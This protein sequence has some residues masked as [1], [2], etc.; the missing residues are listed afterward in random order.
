MTNQYYNPTIVATPGTTVRSAQFNDNNNSLNEGFDKL[1][2]PAVLFTNRQNFAVATSPTANTYVLSINPT[3]VTSLVEG[4]LV[5]FRA[6]SANTGPAQLNLNTLG[7]K[8]IRTQQGEALRAGDIPNAAIITLTFN[9][10][11]DYWQLDTSLTAVAQLVEDAQTAQ[12]AAAGSAAAAATSETNAATS[13]TNAATS[14][15]NAAASATAAAGSATAA[16]ASATA[17]A[18]TQTQIGNA[19]TLA[20]LP[21]VQGQT[22]TQ[23][24]RRYNFMGNLYVAVSASSSNPVA[25]GATPIGDSNWTS[26]GDPLRFFAFETTTTAPTRSF[27]VGQPI[28]SISD[29]FLDTTLQ[30]SSSY[31]F[32]VG[33]RNLIFNQDVPAGTYV[34]IWVGRIKDAYIEA[35]QNFDESA[36][37]SA[38][39]AAT[40]EANAQVSASNALTSAGNAAGSAT[41]AANSRTAAATSE[42]NAQTSAS[43]A[44]QSETNAAASATS[45]SNSATEAAQSASNTFVAGGTF[46]PVAGTEYPS[47]TGLTSRTV[48]I[49]SF[50]T[51]SG[52]YTYTTGDLSGTQ[53]GNQDLL[54]YTPA[55]TTFEL[56]PSSTAAAVSSV[57]GMTG[58]VT[59]TAANV[60]A[61]PSTAT[62]NGVL[63]TSN[64]VFTASTT[65]TGMVQL[66][67]NAET[68]TG[69]DADR[70]VTPAGLASLT[71]TTS[72]RGLI[73]TATNAEAVT[74]TDTERAVTP[75]GLA[76]RL[77]TLPSGVTITDFNLGSIASAITQVTPG[78]PFSSATVFCGG[79][80]QLPGAGNAF[81]IQADGANNRIVFNTSVP[82]GTEVFGFVRA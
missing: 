38:N 19:T 56:I 40:S 80:P 82:A 37:A 46:T 22:A 65:V 12:T 42:T 41:A 36:Q 51:P 57:N 10:P 39:A 73:E 32:T 16:A 50:A 5:R 4:A 48:W 58:A 63:V 31:S 72:R 52:T 25:L 59:L 33:Q 76:A 71:S 6:P 8:Q 24:T 47:T 43:E 15:T 53:V 69:T 3:V 45:A 35:V 20:V 61:V 30:N 60:S 18:N 21:W 17:A 81:T 66:A 70:A 28:D 9:Q 13:E 29:V 2:A 27:D 26:W 75:A 54:L 62:I 44:S 55:T 64:P 1:P 78:V 11:Q 7:L 77:A 79:V 34:K 23:P 67:T 14:E 74:G 49:I 68:Q